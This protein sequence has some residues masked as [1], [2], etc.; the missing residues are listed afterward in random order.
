MCMNV[1]CVAE[2]GHGKMPEIGVVIGAGCAEESIMIGQDRFPYRLIAQ[3]AIESFR[4][5]SEA[6][7]AKICWSQRNFYW[8][9]I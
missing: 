4:V 1:V 2:I 8:C 5:K 3:L 6:M 9:A 7:R